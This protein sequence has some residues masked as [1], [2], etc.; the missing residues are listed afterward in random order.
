MS[1]Y[2]IFFIAALIAGVMMTASE[3]TAVG[4]VEQKARIS[5]R[6]ENYPRPPY[7]GATY[8]IYEREGEVICTKL[9]VCNKYD[10]CSTEYKKGSY[11]DEMDVETGDPYGKTDAVFIR[12]SKL[13][14]HV[15]LTRFKLL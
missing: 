15:C 12:P 13:R 2:M 4:A 7:S 14:K 9:R 10:Q 6:T 1:R 11:K 5:I 8:Y 3:L